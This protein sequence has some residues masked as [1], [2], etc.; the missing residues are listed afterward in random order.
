MKSLLNKVRNIYTKIFMRVKR[1]KMII[2]Y[3]YVMPWWKKHQSDRFFVYLEKANWFRF[4][5][6]R[7]VYVKP[8]DDDKLS[9]AEKCIKKAINDGEWEVALKVV[10]TLPDNAKT[11]RLKQVIEAKIS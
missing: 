9:S 3:K 4:Y 5:G 2:K 11:H 8:K 6:K 10:N 1:I 7:V